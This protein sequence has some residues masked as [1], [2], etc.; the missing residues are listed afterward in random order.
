MLRLWG[1]DNSSNV[2]KVIWLLGE[3]GLNYERKDVGGAF[4]QTETPAYRAMNPTGL[5]PT[6]E[7]DG[8]VL[9]ESNAILR[10]LCQAHAA[11]SAFYPEQPRVR[12]VVDQWLDFQQCELNR[13]LTT[14]FWGLVRTP[15]EKRDPAAIEAGARE[16]ARMWAMVDA[17][18]ERHAYVAGDALTIADMALGVHVHRWFSFEIDRPEASHLR[19][20]YGRLL[21]RPVYAKHIARPLT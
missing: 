19:A 18:L 10:Y 14:V 17:A 7:E 16:C 2:M 13:P 20:W 5:V 21:L 12:A 15:P 3:L 1:R 9:W 11:G 8:F 4:G 6:L